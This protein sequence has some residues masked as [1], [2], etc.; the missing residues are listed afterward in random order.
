VSLKDTL[1][2]VSPA[3]QQ[4]NDVI[5]SLQDMDAKKKFERLKQQGTSHQPIDL[6]EDEKEQCNECFST[7]TQRMT[8]G[9]WLC[10][11][12][13]ANHTCE[14][15]NS[16]IFQPTAKIQPSSKWQTA[17]RLIAEEPQKNFLVFHEWVAD[18]E[19][20]TAYLATLPD[21][22]Q[23]NCVSTYKCRSQNSER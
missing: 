21:V 10:E 9:K 20:F 12:D 3:W 15:C 14:L 16:E 8:C 19:Y 6:D 1:A 5:H 18:R 7:E 2:F 23:G 11:H 13:A 17:A 22:M 4:S